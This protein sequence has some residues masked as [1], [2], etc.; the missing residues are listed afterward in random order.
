MREPR[1]A[2]ACPADGSLRSQTGGQRDPHQPHRR[3][4]PP[5][6]AEVPARPRRHDHG[7][8]RAAR[9]A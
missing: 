9:A 1:H 7:C 2:T 6:G 3:V 8:A 4:A 5:A